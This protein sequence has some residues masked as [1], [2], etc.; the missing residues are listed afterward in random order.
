VAFVT[1]TFGLMAAGAVVQRLTGCLPETP[2]VLDEKEA[3]RRQK[4]PA[5]RRTDRPRLGRHGP[6]VPPGPRH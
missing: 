1:A 3:R 6:L 5:G 2:R 4:R